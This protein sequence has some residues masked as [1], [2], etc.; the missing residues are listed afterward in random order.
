MNLQ[1]IF[2]NW[3]F[4]NIK[5]PH[6]WEACLLA[7][8]VISSGFYNFHCRAGFLLLLLFPWVRFVSVHLFS[9]SPLRRELL[10]GSFLG[11]CPIGV[12]LSSVSFPLW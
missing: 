6:D 10:C 4:N 12:C 5:S 9:G 3:P 2:A 11:T 8:S 1:I 7:S